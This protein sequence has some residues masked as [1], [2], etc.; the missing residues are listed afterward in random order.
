MGEVL[1]GKK[2][3]YK[4]LWIPVW[5]IAA[6]AKIFPILWVGC[7][8]FFKRWRMALAASG[9]CLVVFLGFALLKP[10]AN[11][12]YWQRYLVDRAQQYSRGGTDI[13]DQS[14]KSFLD[15][16]G[17]SSHFVVSGI[18]VD[19][20]QEVKWELPWE[21][22]T[23][24]I[25]WATAAAA[26]LIGL[27]IV[28]SWIRCRNRDPAVALYSLMLFTLIFFPNI[29]RYN[30]LLALPVMAWLWNNGTQGRRLAIAAYALFALSRLN[31]IWAVLLPTP[32]API[33][34]GFGLFGIF[35]L[36]VIEFYLKI[37]VNSDV[38]SNVTHIIIFLVMWLFASK[39]I[40][41][42]NND[43]KIGGMKISN[44]TDVVLSIL[45][46]LH[47]LGMVFYFTYKLGIT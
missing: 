28:Y 11:R 4:A 10:D 38:T 46:V 33:A 45:I 42:E 40:H 35:I 7:L 14:L 24:S 32:L 25:Y 6:A 36:L 12:D 43:N 39:F 44:R 34:S 27:W 15:R 3:S 17:R 47:A 30:H 31:H 2:R 16:I 1:R 19:E 37:R 13:D 41:I 29:Q 21:V 9:L 20:R 5:T 26:V 18:S 8:P 22:S 23:R